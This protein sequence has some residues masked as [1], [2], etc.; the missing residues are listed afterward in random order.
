MDEL[1]SEQIAY[2]RA[3]APQYDDWWHRTGVYVLPDDRKREW[4]EEIERLE[5]AVAEL[6]PTGRVLELAA[7]TG[8][9][10]RHLVR[11]AE[12][13]TAVDAS[14]EALRINAGR[15]AGFAVRYVEADLFAWKPAEKY[16]VVFFSFWLSHVPPER[17]AEFWAMVGSALVP[18]GRAIFIDNRWG[19]GTWRA[20]DERPTEPF[21]ERRDLADGRVFR[22]V[23]IYYEPAELE[24]ELTR[25]GWTSH[26]TTTG[27]SFLLGWAQPPSGASP[28]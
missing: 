9:W 13:V 17:F 21:Q 3:R 7:G 18:G 6:R 8:L 15:L 26:V 24:E 27:R 20:I 14:P 11:Y 4:D 23:K 10:T 5:A 2:Y 19:D 16:D 12:E 28:S 22:I 1:L 25:V